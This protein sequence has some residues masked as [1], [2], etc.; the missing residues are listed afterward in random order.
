MPTT[1]HSTKMILILHCFDEHKQCVTS[2]RSISAGF[3][4][5]F[6]AMS[7]NEGV[8]FRKE[9]FWRSRLLTDPL[10]KK[11]ANTLAPHKKSLKTAANQRKQSAT[12][13][14]NQRIM[15][16]ITKI[17][18]N[19]WKVCLLTFARKIQQS[20]YK[21]GPIKDSLCPT[22][23]PTPSQKVGGASAAAPLCGFLSGLVWRG[24]QGT[25]NS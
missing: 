5:E 11:Y 19:Q 12:I 16:W 14:T 17:F 10:R 23:L 13:V 20:Y 9:L 7:E 1:Y 8:R 21:V 6:S 3:R 18:T 22:N 24:W 15:C 4:A 25:R 2:A